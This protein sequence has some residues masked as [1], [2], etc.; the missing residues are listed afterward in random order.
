M[1]VDVIMLE[2]LAVN[3]HKLKARRHQAV[4]MLSH[5]VCIIILGEIEIEPDPQV[6]EWL[7]LKANLS[8]SLQQ[9]HTAMKQ[10]HNVMVTWSSIGETRRTQMAR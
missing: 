3:Y 6:R 5:D 2:T 7:T 4:R 8:L 1:D 9:Y 10:F